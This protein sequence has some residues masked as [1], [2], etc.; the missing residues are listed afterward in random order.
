[1]WN[2]MVYIVPSAA[3]AGRGLVTFVEESMEV[4]PQHWMITKN[5]IQDSHRVEPKLKIVE[6]KIEDLVSP[7]TSSVL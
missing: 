4:Y 5:G 7:S 3:N 6:D 1:M 2:L